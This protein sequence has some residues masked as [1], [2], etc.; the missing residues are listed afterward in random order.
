MLISGGSGG[1]GGALAEALSEL[2][3]RPILGYA[4]GGEAAR[5]H[6]ERCGGEAIALDLTDPSQ[7]A[8]A[9]ESLCDGRALAGVVLAATAPLVLKSFVHLTSD[10]LDAQWRVHVQGPRQLLAGL[11]QGAFRR[12]HRGFV[13]GILSQAMGSPETPATSMLG[14]YVVAKHALAGLLA[15]L[16]ADYPWLRVHTVRPGFTD[17]SLLDAFDP[18]LLEQLRAHSP[19]ARPEAVASDIAGRIG[20]PM[21]EPST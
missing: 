6:A 4:R 5:K 20:P 15:A 12:P 2:G 1:I 8:R 14:A 19:F 10:D 7:I 3:Y 17:T 9:L 18:R 21:A 16:A 11:V 13:V